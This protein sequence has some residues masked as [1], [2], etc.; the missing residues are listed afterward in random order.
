MPMITINR[1]D[2]EGLVGK[3]LGDEEIIEYLSMLKCEVD[4][5]E[6]D[7]IEYEANHDRPDLFSAEGAARAIRLLL[8]IGRNSFRFRDKG[9]KAY[10]VDVHYRPYVAFAAVLDVELSDEAVAQI[11]QLQEKL[12]ITYGRD[13]RKASIGV[14][15]LDRIKPPV[16]Y[17]L[18]DPLETRFV[19]LGETREMSL[20]EILEETE[21]GIRYAH[22]LKPHDKY[23]VLRD[24]EGRILS[25]P[26]IINSEDTKVTVDTRN[27]L[28]D[29]TGIDPGIVVDMVTV[30]ATSIAERSR[31]R[32]I[33][34]VETMYSGGERIRAPRRKGPRV[35][36]T[37]MDAE[38]LLGIRLGHDEV[39]RLLKKMGYSVR[40]KGDKIIAEA[41]PYR[42]DVF[43]WVDAVEDIAM[44]LGY[45]SIGIKADRL[46]PA[47]HPGRPAASEHLTRRLRLLMTGL[48]FTEMPSYMMSSPAAQNELFGADEPLVVV[49]NP[50]MEK[51][52]CL[53]RWLTPGL[54]ETA[55][56]NISRRTEL[57]IFEAGD[58]VIVDEESPTGARS[59]R[60]LGALIT[61]ED[62][63][64]TDMLAVLRTLMETLG[65]RYRLV[66]KE[67]KGL[68]PERTAAVMVGDTEIGFVGEIHP[69]V[70]LRIG[71][72]QPVVV[73]ELVVD[74]LVI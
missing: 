65:T 38:R 24:S 44:A 10:S 25:M 35:D 60:R 13:R 63:T 33:V 9:L 42:L 54:L 21:K 14:Y 19:P 62:A 28:I 11:M 56:A 48:G 23:P 12:H 1:R 39:S 49:A 3:T 32:V 53:R 15:D 7:E 4:R 73:M 45:Y 30:M 50:K 5:L 16:Y 26:P 34:Y 69:S 6:G 61:R 46:P 41:P 59:E 17:E 31:D 57:R 64:L 66:K 51:Y 20:E 18:R 68:L 43:R 2:L 40:I 37:L 8:G 74:R 29:S 52:T 47:H 70:L 22:L 71:I 55:K 58:V 72:D 36:F 67:V 27:I